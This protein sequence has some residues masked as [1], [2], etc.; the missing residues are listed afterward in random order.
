MRRLISDVLQKHGYT[1]LESG[2]GE[3]ALA[4]AQAYRGDI[5]LLL[6][7]VVMPGLN[8]GS[9]ARRLCAGRPDVQVL[10]TTGYSERVTKLAGADEL[11]PL[12]MKPYPPR[13]LLQRV[14]EILDKPLTTS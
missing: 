1:V 14:R 10:Y 3:D 11:V 6:T 4:I 8:G 2:D 9:L 12:L 5:H 13:A 7:D